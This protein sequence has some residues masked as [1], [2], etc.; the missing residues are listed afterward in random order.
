MRSSFVAPISMASA[1]SAISSCRQSSRSAEQR[2]PAERKA[3]VEN[4]VDHLLEQ[5]GR[6]DDHGVDAAGLG[7]ER[8]DRTIASGERA[9]N[10]ARGLASSR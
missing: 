8:N 4:I 10:G 1:S 6:I 2:W 7:D 5:S 3:E 9:M